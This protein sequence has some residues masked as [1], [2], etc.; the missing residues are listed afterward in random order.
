MATD[1]FDN[2]DERHDTQCEGDSGGRLACSCGRRQKRRVLT[3]MH[4]LRAAQAR[5]AAIEAAARDVVAEW[6]KPASEVDMA[7]AEVGSRLDDLV[8]VLEEEQSG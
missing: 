4:T 8:L 7:E 3:E 2:L 5:S 1:V 6:S